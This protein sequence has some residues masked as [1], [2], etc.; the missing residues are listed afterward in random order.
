MSEICFALDLFRGICLFSFGLELC[1]EAFGSRF[2]R[3]SYAR[4]RAN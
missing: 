1:W 2:S 4:C 3:W